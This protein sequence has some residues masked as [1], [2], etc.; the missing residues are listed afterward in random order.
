VVDYNIEVAHVYFDDNRLQS[1]DEEVFYHN[2]ASTEIARRMIDLIESRGE[3]YSVCVLIDDQRLHSSNAQM[4][5]PFL[6]AVSREIRLDYVCYET[7]LGREFPA[8][9]DSLVDP[10]PIKQ[11]V[12]GKYGGKPQCSH[13]IAIWHMMR[14]GYIR[15]DG[16]AIPLPSG[17]HGAARPFAARQAISILSRFH[18]R[19]EKRARR[20]LLLRSRRPEITRSIRCIY[21]PPYVGQVA[22]ARQMVESA[23]ADTFLAEKREKG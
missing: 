21:Y 19:H 22:T 8:L 11:E 23:R 1:L 7:A 16:L 3:R 15:S 17:V 14:L 9:L 5:R 6:E 12:D 18:R 10:L 4:F 2:R 20:R 13:Y